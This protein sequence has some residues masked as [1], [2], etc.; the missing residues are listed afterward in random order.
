MLLWL[1]IKT[2]KLPISLLSGRRS[3]C[4]PTNLNHNPSI[5][6]GNQALCSAEKIRVNGWY[7]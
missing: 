4:T 2:E 5:V 1:M 6:V 7:T 3:P